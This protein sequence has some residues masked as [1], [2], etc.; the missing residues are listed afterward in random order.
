MISYL[1]LGAVGVA[2]VLLAWL[3][4]RG[5]ERSVDPELTAPSAR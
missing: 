3:W 5:R 1:A 2:L 4:L